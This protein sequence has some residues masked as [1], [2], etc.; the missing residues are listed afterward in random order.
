M[1]ASDIMSGVTVIT[2][3][4][5]SRIRARLEAMERGPNWLARKLGK[6]PTTVSGWLAGRHTP[7]IAQLREIGAV[8]NCPTAWLLGD[9]RRKA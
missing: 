1:H 2:E 7:S 3:T 8:L 9:D 4:V 6:H 5:G